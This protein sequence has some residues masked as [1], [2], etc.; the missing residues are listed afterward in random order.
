MTSPTLD[1]KL[2]VRELSDAW[3]W[4]RHKITRLVNRN[5]IPHLRVGDE[6]FFELSALEPWLAARRRGDSSRTGGSGRTRAQERADLGL[7]GDPLFG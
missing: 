4:S 7:S 6:V 2:T 1:R 5:A 3:G